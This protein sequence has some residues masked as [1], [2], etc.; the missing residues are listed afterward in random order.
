MS[1]R[2]N[3]P[4]QVSDQARYQPVGETDQQLIILQAHECPAAVVTDG[5]DRL[6]LDKGEGDGH[7]AGGF[8]CVA[9]DKLRSLKG[10]GG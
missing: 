6:V 1:L 7:Q 5:E 2:V 8:T 3:S 9:G 4:A 10:I